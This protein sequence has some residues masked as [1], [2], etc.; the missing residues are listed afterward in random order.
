M[1]RA[2][3]RAAIAALLESA[4]V[5][6]GKPAEAV[7]DHLKPDFGGASPVVAVAS[8]GSNRA[9]FAGRGPRVEH[10]LDIYVFV[11]RAEAGVEESYS[12]EEADAALDAIE[13][14]V[15]EVVAANEETADWHLAQYAGES[16][17]I[18]AEIGGE[19]YW[20]ERIPLRFTLY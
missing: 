5:G 4:L 18:T 13:A 8:A 17:I 20:M 3:I 15:A 16:T 12:A 6:T 9:A 19:Q 10:E 1:S 2:T 14:K 7:Y 11:L